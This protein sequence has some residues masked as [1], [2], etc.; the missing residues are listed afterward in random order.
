MKLFPK[1][2]IQ[3][4]T[5]FMSPILIDCSF[6]KGLWIVMDL[7]LPSYWA[8]S[9]WNL[10]LSNFLKV[11][12]QTECQKYDEISVPFKYCNPVIMMEI[13][14]GALLQPFICILFTKLKLY[15]TS[16]FKYHCTCFYISGTNFIQLCVSNFVAT[17]WGCDLYECDIQVYTNILA[18]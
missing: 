12:H 18:V 14:S 10:N 5:M 2:G 17:V 16:C 13:L 3:K 8:K 15:C 11:Y 9:L 1:T 7:V 4:K 6:S